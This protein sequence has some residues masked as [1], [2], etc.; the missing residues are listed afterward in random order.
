MAPIDYFMG[1]FV[2]VCVGL[3][4]LA[5]VNAAAPG[6]WLP[7]RRSGS[8]SMGAISRA[9]DGRM[10]VRPF[11]ELPPKQTAARLSTGGLLC[12][13]GATTFLLASEN[14]PCPNRCAILI[15][16]Q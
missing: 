7:Y 14:R 11:F 8:V 16:R 12:G 15:F 3:A 6:P 1:L 10:L 5:Y 4:G 2:G 9:P 13:D